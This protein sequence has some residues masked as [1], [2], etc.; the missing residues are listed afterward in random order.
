MWFCR[1]YVF[2][3]TLH[4]SHPVYDAHSG[5]Q[6]SPC[7]CCTQPWSWLRI[8]RDYQSLLTHLGIISSVTESLA[9]ASKSLQYITSM[10]LVSLCRKMQTQVPKAAVLSWNPHFPLAIYLVAS[11]SPYP[12]S[13]PPFCLYFSSPRYLHLYW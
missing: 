2:F 4:S 12:S 13:I 9:L 11:F 7:D 5:Q 1:D 8:N 3:P 10:Q 6:H